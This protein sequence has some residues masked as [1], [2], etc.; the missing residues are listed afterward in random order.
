MNDPSEYRNL[1]EIKPEIV[2]P[3]V[4]GYMQWAESFRPPVRWSKEKW[5][6]IAGR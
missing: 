3:L 6:E 2:E 1:A 5:E 4:D